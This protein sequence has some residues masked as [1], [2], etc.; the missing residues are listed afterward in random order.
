MKRR[1]PEFIFERLIWRFRL[2]SVLPVIMSLLGS[3]N[4][5]LLG[6][7]EEVRAMQ[8]LSKQLTGGHWGTLH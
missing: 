4:C 3:V 8:E 2:V 6:T 5:F 7:A 1:S